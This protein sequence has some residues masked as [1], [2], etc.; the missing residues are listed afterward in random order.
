MTAFLV[1]PIVTIIVIPF[2]KVKEKGIVTFSA[3]VINA[4]ISSL[5]AIKALSGQILDFSLAGSFVTGP[6]RMQVDALSG[7]FVLILNLVFV[8]G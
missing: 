3:I 5:F 7:W 6:I 1:L 2:L 4:F 8:T